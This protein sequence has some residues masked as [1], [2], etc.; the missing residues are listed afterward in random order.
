MSDK[1]RRN[2]RELEELERIPELKTKSVK[3]FKEL[4]F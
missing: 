2:K 3:Y 1:E 4:I